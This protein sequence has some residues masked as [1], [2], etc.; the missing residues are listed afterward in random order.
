VPFSVSSTRVD[1]VAA[2]A[3]KWLGAPPGTGLFFCRRER[4]PL[5]GSAPLGWFGYDGSDRIFGPGEGHLVY[6]LPP[7]PA[8]RRFEGGMLNFVGI[9]GLAAALSEIVAVG[10]ETV[11]ARVRGLTATLREALAELG[12][13]AGEPSTPAAGSGIVGFAPSRGRF[14]IDAA[15]LQAD[16]AKRD[17][18]CSSLDGHIRLSPHYWTTADEVGLFLDALRTIVAAR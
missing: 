4:L 6:D 10:A 17:C 12:Y 14:A 7:R 11:W 1:F 3:H 8:A 13:A 15:H 18:H 16:L 5:L 9:A 2:G